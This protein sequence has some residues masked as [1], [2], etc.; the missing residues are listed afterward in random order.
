M[1]AIQNASNTS[2]IAR[3]T[4]SQTDDSLRF[5]N[6]SSFA[7]SSLRFGNNGLDQVTIDLAGNVGIG[8]SSPATKLNI[9]PASYANGT[10]VAP[11]FQI[12]Y[13]GAAGSSSTSQGAICWSSAGVQTGAITTAFDNPSATYNT[14]MIFYTSNSTGTNTE[15]MRISSGGDL[16]IGTT[17]TSVQKLRIDGTQGG[18]FVTND[19]LNH[20]S[21][22]ALS[23]S[24]SSAAHYVLGILNSA[25]TTVGAI[26][27]NN[28]TTTYA[29]S[30]DYRL[31]EN[32]APMTGALDVVQALKP[33]TYK[34]KS[35]GSDGQGFIAHELQKVVPDCVTGEKDAMRTEK[36]E[37]SP[38]IP[39][40]VDE[41]GKV[42]K[43]AVEAVMGEREV[44]AYQG[45]DTS[46]LVATLTAAIQELNAKVTT[47]EEQVLT[48]S[49]K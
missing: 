12:E 39:A 16:L 20:Y 30:S 3:I 23:K 29:T 24:S 40:E 15:R 6:M 19:D 42:I 27:H 5:A 8:T 34:W 31:K 28:T 32:I 21:Y 33:V 13:S 11:A 46:F 25:G 35:D 37:I 48:L 14:A 18:I 45:I 1:F 36:Y 44:P 10:A 7:G 2:S 43:E 38:A 22:L 47:L 4:Y 49:V 41:D 9:K 26:T 17:A